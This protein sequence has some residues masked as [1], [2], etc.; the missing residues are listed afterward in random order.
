MALWVGRRTFHCTH[1]MKRAWNVAD[2]EKL[3]K[4]HTDYGP[5]WGVVS[6]SFPSRSPRE[7]RKRWLLL[8]MAISTADPALQSREER[9]LIEGYERHGNRWI[10]FPVEDPG[11]SPFRRIAAAI[12]W[13]KFARD[14]RKAGWPLVE[15][16]ALREGFEQHGRNWSFIANQMSK[17]SATEC[18]KRLVEEFI[19][20]N[21]VDGACKTT[22]DQDAARNADKN[23]KVT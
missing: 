20:T 6:R 17:R 12:P 14:K 13:F 9:L 5:V 11:P 2:D 8:T 21:P 18:Q 15:R 4:T 3:L 1:I 23:H 16:M 22:T 10:R 7:C 19:L